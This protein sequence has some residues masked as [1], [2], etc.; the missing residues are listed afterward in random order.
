MIFGNVGQSF[1]QI[2]LANSISGTLAKEQAGVGMG[3]FSMLNFISM[4]IASGIYSKV[5]DLGA[6]TQWNPVNP[7]PVGFVY[8]N[9]Y[10]VLA[11]LHALIFLFYYSGSAKPVAPACRPTVEA[12]P[13]KRPVW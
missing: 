6:T 1:M 12:N 13:P 8:S 3:I 11:A 2:T 7:Y 10:L 5:I 9:I 4:G